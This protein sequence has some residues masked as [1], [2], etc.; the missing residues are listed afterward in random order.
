MTSKKEQ[1]LSK[2]FTNSST[3]SGEFTDFAGERYYVIRNV[4][5]MAP[6]FVSV[7]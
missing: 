5:K 1:A 4:D 3:V 2:G 7:I 6:F